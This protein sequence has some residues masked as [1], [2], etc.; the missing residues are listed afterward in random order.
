M[1]AMDRAASALRRAHSRHPLAV[2]PGYV[3]SPMDSH[4]TVS[5]SRELIEACEQQTKVTLSKSA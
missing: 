4:P 3:L 2:T 1:K 5:I